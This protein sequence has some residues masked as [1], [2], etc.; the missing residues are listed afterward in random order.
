ML[1]AKGFHVFLQT[2]VQHIPSQTL[3]PITHDAVPELVTASHADFL[4]LVADRNL[5]PPTVQLRV[6]AHHD[7][8]DVPLSDLPHIA[9]D[10]WAQNIRRVPDHLQSHAL[11]MNPNV[12]TSRHLNLFLQSFA[13]FPPIRSTYA[14]LARLVN[15]TQHWQDPPLP[16]AKPLPVSTDPSPVSDSSSTS[17]IA[18]QSPTTDIDQPSSVEQN[19]SSDASKSESTSS[20]NSNPSLPSL[21]ASD[22]NCAARA[23]WQALRENAPRLDTTLPAK[24]DLS[25][26]WLRRGQHLSAR[27]IRSQLLARRMHRNLLSAF[28]TISTVPIAS[29]PTSSYSQMHLPTL[30]HRQR[31]LREINDLLP[32]IEQL[33][34]RLTKRPKSPRRRRRHFINANPWMSYIDNATAPSTGDGVAGV[35]GRAKQFIDSGG[36][37]CIGCGT[38]NDRVVRECSACGGPSCHVDASRLPSDSDQLKKVFIESMTNGPTPGS[39]WLFAPG[40]VPPPPPMNAPVNNGVISPDARARDLRSAT[41]RGDELSYFHPGELTLGGAAPVAVRDGSSRRV[42]MDDGMIQTTGGYDLNGAFQELSFD[43]DPATGLNREL[44]PV[45]ASLKANMLGS[46]SN[47]VHNSVLSGDGGSSRSPVRL[48][49]SQPNGGGGVGVPPMINLALQRVMTSGLTDNSPNLAG[50][51]SLANGIIGR[52][53]GGV[54]AA[55]GNSN[56]VEGGALPGSLSITHGY[57]SSAL[58]ENGGM[59]SSGGG[60]EKRGMVGKSNVGQFAMEELAAGSYE[61]TDDVHRY[62]GFG[63][64]GSTS[65][66]GGSGG[67]GS[68]GVGVSEGAVQAAGGPLWGDNVDSMQTMGQADVVPEETN[69]L[70]MLAAASDAANGGTGSATRESLRAVSA[71]VTPGRS[72]GSSSS[73][74]AHEGW[75]GTY[76][77]F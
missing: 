22:V 4:I 24:C 15:I 25:Y 35:S 69:S 32:R 67:G 23:A 55:S 12:V 10:A 64:R 65:G 75:N 3:T 52:S 56:L 7:F 8:I 29:S 30:A 61:A 37:R 72:H 36:W 48:A 13:A 1:S 17:P 76:N 19:E 20:T 18:Q 60:D 31:L 47:S 53:G 46:G 41:A 40:T 5:H 45:H 73:T 42:V 58:F 51:E 50:M 74:R 57:V 27:L 70:E 43:G 6:A 28:D 54:L 16:A 62:N 66:G 14:R 9:L 39:P 49:S 77:M 44:R 33:A 59:H 34:T 11:A 21:P 2:E 68:T 71:L 63:R 26:S 38:C